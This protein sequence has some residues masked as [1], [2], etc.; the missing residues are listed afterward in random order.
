MGILS[1][2]DSL[3]E[4]DS[5]ESLPSE[6]KGYLSKSFKKY[7]VT[8]LSI[9]GAIATREA[10]GFQNTAIAITSICIAFGF[11]FPAISSSAS[12]KLNSLKSTQL[13]TES[14][15][16]NYI[17]EIFKRVAPRIQKN[18]ILGGAAGLITSLGI[19]AIFES[20]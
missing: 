11:V 7:L 16:K 15:D 2:S 4:I 18:A 17:F 9:S 5:Y 6:P 13:N 1:T 19:L 14:E 12:L 10:L 8:G 20:S 3:L